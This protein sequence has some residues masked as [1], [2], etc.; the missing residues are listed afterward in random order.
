MTALFASTAATMSGTGPVCQSTMDA[1]YTGRWL[2]AAADG[3]DG[4]RAR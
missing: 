4:E 3:P 1:A 2:P